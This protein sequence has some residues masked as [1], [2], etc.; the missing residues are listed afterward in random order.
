MRKAALVTTWNK[1]GFVEVEYVV[2]VKQNNTK[3]KTKKTKMK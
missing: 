3:Q 1:I 2:E